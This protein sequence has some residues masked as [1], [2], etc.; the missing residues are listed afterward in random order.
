MRI[1]TVTIAAPTADS[2][3]ASAFFQVQWRHQLPLR[4]AAAARAPATAAAAVPA[5]GAGALFGLGVA[6]GPPPSGPVPGSRAGP[7]RPVLPA[8][9]G[10]GATGGGATARAVASAAAVAVTAAVTCPPRP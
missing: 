9:A 10:A 3:T 2:T 5:A 7:R 4:L 6:H 8:A 1:A